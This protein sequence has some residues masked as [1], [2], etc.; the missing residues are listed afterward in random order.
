MMS[1]YKRL[2]PISAVASFLKQLKELI[3]PF[4][5]LFV[6]NSR[7]EKSGFWDYMPLISMGAVLVIVLVAGV[8]KWLRFTYRLEEG[9]L[10]IE[11]GLFVK[12][13][14]YIPFDRIQSLNFSEGIIHRPFGLVK[15]KVETAG[16]SNPRESEAELT[17][18]LKEE[19]LDLE[20]IIYS[21]KK[22][23][24]QPMQADEEQ[25]IDVAAMPKEEKWVFNM[26]AKDILVLAL[27]S[28]GVG[29]IL[30]GAAVFLSQLSDFIPYEMIFDEIMVFVK[31]GLVI[32]AVMSFVI[33]LVAWIFSVAWTFVLYGD[34]KIRLSDENIVI[35]RGLLEK[36]QITVPLNRVQGIRVVENPVR[37]LFGYCTVVI[38]NAGGSVLEKDS[39]TIK[40]MPVVKK[41]RVPGLLNEIFPEYILTEDF[42]RLPKR[43]LRRYIFRAADWVIIPVIIMAIMYW[44]LG[45]FSILLAV[46]F[47]LLG[48]FQHRTGGWR[49]NDNQLSLR[50]RGI[51][52]HTAYMKK[53]RIQSLDSRQSWFQARRNLSSIST[54]LKSG[55]TGYSSEVK[56]LELED[57]A[58]IYKWFSH[59]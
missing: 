54:T 21:E 22:K 4:V 32:I 46:P 56:D 19:A 57:A 38:E 1:E 52:K 31:S 45:L 33:L 12:K 25:S 30:S 50:Y 8:I 40:L 14:R 6:L 3:I 15:V 29:V 2:H 53:S 9:E 41:K 16:S 24:Q 47:G 43:A 18:I 34:F 39:S 28:G 5:L 20:R 11:Y 17:A 35:T 23:D 49:I 10:R 37:Q 59:E 55:Q 26:S 36:K 51:L 58:E 42:Q 48:F 13:K 44:P 27:T 7:G